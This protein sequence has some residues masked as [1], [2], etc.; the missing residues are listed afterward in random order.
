MEFSTLLG[1]TFIKVE[2]FGNEGLL[3]T[4]NDGEFYGLYHGQ[5]CCESVTIEDICGDLVDLEGSPILLASEECSEIRP[6][7]VVEELHEDS[8]VLWTFYKLS[9]L[10]GSVTIRWYGTSNG[11]YSVSV[12]FEQFTSSDKFKKMF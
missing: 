3:F 4:T 2:N 9:T 7:G 10:K 8:A 1:K 11:Y 6:E 5:N 12:D